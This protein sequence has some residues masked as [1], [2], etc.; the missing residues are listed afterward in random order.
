MLDVVSGICN[1]LY[2][3]HLDTVNFSSYSRTYFGN[4]GFN[5]S[6]GK[7]LNAA[8][9]NILLMY[10]IEQTTLNSA[11]LTPYVALPEADEVSNAL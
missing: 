6:E 1:G 5:K 4:F 3:N 7:E 8:A 11:S 2:F 10:M 9:K